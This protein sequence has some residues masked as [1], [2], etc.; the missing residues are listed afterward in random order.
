MSHKNLVCLN[1][2]FYLLILNMLFGNPQEAFSQE[3]ID[4]DVTAQCLPHSEIQAPQTLQVRFYYQTHRDQLPTLMS[5]LTVDGILNLSAQIIQW[6]SPQPS[7]V[8]TSFPGPPVKATLYCD[9]ASGPKQIHLS[10]EKKRNLEILLS[11]NENPSSAK[12][13]DDLNRMTSQSTLTVQPQGDFHNEYYLGSG[14]PNGYGLHFAIPIHS[15]HEIQ[16]QIRFNF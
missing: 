1:L 11:L 8:S 7:W 9:D 4:F 5:S 14:S 2:V 15:S 10:Y 6:D 13:I 12:E 16:T 3:K